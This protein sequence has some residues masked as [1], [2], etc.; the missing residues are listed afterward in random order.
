MPNRHTL[1]CTLGT[2]LFGNLRRLAETP[3]SDSNREALARAYSSGDW[4]GVSSRLVNIP[5]TEQ[6]CGAEI[7]SVEILSSNQVE[8]V[9]L[10]LL[11]SDTTDG[12]VIA[13]VLQ[14]YFRAHGWQKVYCHSLEGLRDDDPKRFRTE[15][16][17]NLAKRC[18]ELV[19]VAGGPEYCAINATGGYK[20]QIAIAVLIGQ[21]LD[22]P[23]YYKH[24]FFRTDAIIS[25]PPMP[26]ALDFSLWERA[27]GMFMTLSRVNSFEP[28]EHF[29]DDWDER[30]E[31]LV[32]RIDV[33]GTDYLEL[34]PT[35]QIFHQTFLQRFQHS[36]TERLPSAAAPSDKKEP[37]LGKHGYGQAQPAI[38]NFLRK[39]TEEVPYVLSCSTTYWNPRLPASTLFRRSSHGIEGVYSDR[40]WCVKFAVETTARQNDP[41]DSL[42]VVVAD[43]N[44]WLER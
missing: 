29:K 32:E 16:L 9:N 3:Q 22:I 19:R 21:A 12:R 44:Q 30:F 26:V 33:D 41:A 36:K 18:G 13:D 35:G 28:W 39:L 11:H 31:P 14:S 4:T 8:P 43:L 24:E 15:G 25:F 37:S 5:P 6:I 34:S 1:I 10:H 23:V 27:S 38:E 17:R 40:T 2:S 42:N 7:N 20:A